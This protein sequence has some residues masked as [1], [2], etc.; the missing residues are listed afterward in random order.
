MDLR[1]GRVSPD[2]CRLQRRRTPARHAVARRISWARIEASKTGN[3]FDA[4]DA[5]PSAVRVWDADTGKLAGPPLV[6]RAA[7][8]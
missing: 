7:A 5:T 3:I 6:Q 2:R 1:G 8:T 4:P